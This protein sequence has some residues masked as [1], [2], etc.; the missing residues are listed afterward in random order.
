MK[1]CVQLGEG[2]RRQGVGVLSDVCRE[3]AV[4]SLVP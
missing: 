1:I 2:C 4:C 3:S